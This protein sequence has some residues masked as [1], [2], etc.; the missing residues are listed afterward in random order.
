[1]MRKCLVIFLLCAWVLWGQVVEQRMQLGGVPINLISDWQQLGH[2]SKTLV[3]C[4]AAA[5]LSMALELLV[6][7]RCL[8]SPTP[9]DPREP[10]RRP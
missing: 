4:E 9:T 8:R 10:T 2:G 3:E 1:M 6:D 7:W 5:K